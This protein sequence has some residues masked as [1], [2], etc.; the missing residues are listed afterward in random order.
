MGNRCMYHGAQQDSATHSRV[1]GSG[2][3]GELLFRGVAVANTD[4]DTTAVTAP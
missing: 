2:G 3:R 4:G 1:P